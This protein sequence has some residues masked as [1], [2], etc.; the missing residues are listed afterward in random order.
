MQPVTLVCEARIGSRTPVVG[1]KGDGQNRSAIT[2]AAARCIVQSLPVSVLNSHVR[3]CGRFLSK[4]SAGMFD[5]RTACDGTHDK[6][7]QNFRD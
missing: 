7:L 3:T 2:S 1:Q 4:T 5:D 6:R